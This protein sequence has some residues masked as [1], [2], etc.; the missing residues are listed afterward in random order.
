MPPWRPVEGW[1]SLDRLDDGA[2]LDGTFVLAFKITDDGTDPWSARMNRFKARN[3]EALYGA[4]AALKAG[5]PSLL[6]ALRLD[7]ARTVLVPAISSRDRTADATSFTS[8]LADALARAVGTGFDRALVSKQ[9]H[10]PLHGIFDAAGRTAEV[11]K[12]NYAARRLAGA[13][14]FVIV[15]DLVTRGSTMSRMALALKAANPGATV[16][17]VALGKTE[18]RA[19]WGALSN[20][21]VDPRWEDA[22][23]R[24]ER[25][26]RDG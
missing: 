24:G 19:Y 18:R 9:A 13:R 14:H 17:G 23:L 12:A 26:Y 25:K 15:D 4:A 20:D 1:M 10:Q 7:L 5:L 16:H 11:E 2:G 8:R 22:W 3:G 21:H 6:A